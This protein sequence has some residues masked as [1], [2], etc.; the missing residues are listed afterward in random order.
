MELRSPIMMQDENVYAVVLAGGSGTR[1]WPESRRACPKQF[2]RIGSDKTLLELT[3]ARLDGFVPAERRVV[4]TQQAHYE[5]MAKVVRVGETNTL[6]AEIVAEPAGRGTLAAVSLAT[7]QLLVRDPKAVV[8]SLHS[9]AF[10][11]D[12]SALQCALAAAVVAARSDYLVLLGA[13]PHYAAT[14]YD[15]IVRGAP[16]ESLQNVYH[17]RFLYHP[18]QR[19]ADEFVQT[20]GYF[21]NSGIFVWRAA[22][23]RR[24]LQASRPQVERVL[25]ACLS[26]AGG[27]DAVKLHKYY[28]QLEETSV[29]GGVV[30][31][32]SRCA[33]LPLDCGWLDI[34]SWDMLAQAFDVDKDGNLALG[35]VLMRACRGTTVK[36]S[37]L[38]VVTLGLKDVIV[39]ATADAVLVCA[40][41]RAQE[42]RDLVARLPDG[43][44]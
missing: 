5:R 13:K 22:L 42:V 6:A 28:A 33:M 11:R 36:T 14:N 25:S 37:G 44:V 41:E 8:I 26:D 1:L 23:F 43:V 27:I 32:S 12:V 31:P 21:W 20:D 16:I 40:K 38:Q 10:I 7:L 34:G 24:E 4:V 35:E 15:Y 3:L 39:I 18:T 17:A 19:E 2:C 9:D 30:A 29:D